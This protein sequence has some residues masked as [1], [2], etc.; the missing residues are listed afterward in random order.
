MQF[1]IAHFRYIDADKRRHDRKQ[2]HGNAEKDQRR[3]AVL[4]AFPFGFFGTFSRRLFLMKPLFFGLDMFFL[5]THGIISF[6]LREFSPSATANNRASPETTISPAA[7]RT[8]LN[9]APP[10]GSPTRKSSVNAAPMT[11][12]GR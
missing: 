5:L 2:R 4:H 7:P 10:S 9:S 1:V 8:R 3:P 11:A 12:I 6:N